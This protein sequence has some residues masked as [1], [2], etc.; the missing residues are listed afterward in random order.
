[1]DRL[2]DRESVI[3]ESTP[4]DK[5]G[6]SSMVGF[7][8][9][10]VGR[11]CAP[12][13]PN[14]FHLLEVMKK[15][16]RAKKDVTAREWGNKLFL[17][18]FKHR[19]DRD[20]VLNQQP[21]HFENYLFV[22]AALKGNEQPSSVE[23][24]T[25]SFWIRAYDL[26]WNCMSSHNMIDIAQ[27]M[28][29]FE[30]IDTNENYAGSFMR[31]KVIVDITEPLLRGI[32]LKTEDGT[33]WIPLKYESLPIYCFSCGIIGHQSR[34][35]ESMKRVEGEYFDDLQYGPW[36]K[37]SPLKKNRTPSTGNN[38]TG[39]NIVRSL[40]KPN[41]PITHSNHTKSVMLSQPIRPP[42]P[43][44]SQTVPPNTTT[45]YRPPHRR[46]YQQ[47][48]PPLHTVKSAQHMA[49][50]VNLT[51]THPFCPNRPTCLDLYPQPVTKNPT[52]AR[53]NSKKPLSLVDVADT[54][55]ESEPSSRKR[56]QSEM[57]DHDADESELESVYKKLKTS[58]WFTFPANAV[59]TAEIAKE[60]SRRSQ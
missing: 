57:G 49:P 10:L 43:H 53:L 1:M 26:P 19:E 3:V 20:W 45:A 14:S 60:Q 36:I 32:M 52:I 6:E 38:N 21:W 50:T 59:F 34:G 47:I 48:T 55:N 2:T 22:V 18:T 28:G 16:W 35:C 7:T 46:A 27:R 58:E 56:D 54:I 37:A 51:F 33:V 4:V 11:L 5:Q 17:F 42:A 40:F 41:M 13:P 31:F 24:N 44:P 25:C 15:A 29:T 23:V 30:E 8:F 12:K 9:C 39:A